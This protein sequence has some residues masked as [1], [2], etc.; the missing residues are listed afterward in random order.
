MKRVM[1]ETTISEEAYREMKYVCEMY[2]MDEQSF[3]AEAIVEKVDAMWAQLKA[4][5]RAKSELYVGSESAG[6]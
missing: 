4:E 1:I 5:Q 3:A 2:G 6:K